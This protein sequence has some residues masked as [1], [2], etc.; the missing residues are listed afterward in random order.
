MTIKFGILGLGSIAGR[1]ARVLNSLDDA[2]LVAVA[3]R[4][5]HRADDFAKKFGAARSYGNYLDLLRDKSVEAVYVAVTHNFHF[6]LV[7]MSLDHQKA[8]LCEKPLT[9]TLHEAQTL[10]DLANEK[11]ILLME[12]M[13]TRCLPAYRKA[14]EWIA[15]E[16]IGQ[17]RM[18]SAQFHHI[19]PFEPKNR[20]YN[21]AL[22][23][24][25]L[26]DL[27]VY[28][29]E[30]STGLIGAN[31]L[32]AVGQASIGQ[33]GVD[34]MAA[35][36]LQFPNRAMANLS[37]GFA[38]E[39]E[40]CANVYGTQGR[41]V[42]DNCF[43]TRHVQCFDTEGY[44]VDEFTGP[45]ADGF[46]FQIVHFAE[47]YNKG[48]KESDLIPWADTLACATVFDQLQAQWGLHT[49]DN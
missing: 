22:A 40:D 24:G 2:E 19:I 17:V 33:T 38:V 20:F 11:N 42:L 23:G 41:I 29:I 43:R 37:C 13:W 8:V 27:G 1:F 34:E 3:P 44:L 4:D 9:P 15:N 7:K 39:A 35:F 36:S 14:K 46:E 12:A 6:D 48:K 10:V 26:F 28:P 47:L 32:Y 45:D 5:Q 18:I 21:P 16:K 31:P 25:S 49:G 30:F